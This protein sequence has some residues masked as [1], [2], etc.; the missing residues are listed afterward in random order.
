MACFC[1]DN[2][3]HKVRVLPLTLRVRLAVWSWTRIELHPG[4]YKSKNI[5][6]S[7]NSKVAVFT[8]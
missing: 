4:S 2:V 1:V 3:W 8:K 5:E 7:E 6:L